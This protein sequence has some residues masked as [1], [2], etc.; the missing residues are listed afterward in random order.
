MIY[1]KT[2][3]RLWWKLQKSAKGGWNV[4]IKVEFLLTFWFNLVTYFD[5]FKMVPPKGP[6]FSVIQN[7]FMK[8]QASSQGIKSSLSMRKPSSLSKKLEP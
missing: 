4:E 1:L 2:F 7:S 6:F 8:I 3:V 5:T